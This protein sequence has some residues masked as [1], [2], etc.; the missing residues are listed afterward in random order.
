MDYSLKTKIQARK[1]K[2]N[3]VITSKSFTRGMVYQLN[4]FADGYFFR[5]SDIF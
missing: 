1:I 5:F 4:V 3:S 2:N